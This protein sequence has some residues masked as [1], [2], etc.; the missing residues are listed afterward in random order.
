MDKISIK[1]LEVY[2]YHGVY[3][4]E[5]HLG[6]KFVISVD[7]YLDTHPAAEN[8][9]LE[10]SVNY[11]EVCLRVKQ[12][13]EEKTFNLIETAAQRIASCILYSYK[14]VRKVCVEEMCIRDRDGTHGGHKNGNNKHCKAF[15][16]GR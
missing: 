10:K 14:D 16:A 9:D 7:M 8:D 3:E 1:N 12:L 13:M 2:A 4:E 5:N 6:Q 15:P 11:G